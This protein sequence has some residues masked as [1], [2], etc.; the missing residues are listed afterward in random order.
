MSPITY[1]D[2]L[3]MNEAEVERFQAIY[4]GDMTEQQE[5]NRASETLAAMRLPSRDLK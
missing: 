3:E 5:A 1:F 4:R 2:E